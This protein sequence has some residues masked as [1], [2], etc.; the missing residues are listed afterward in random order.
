MGHSRAQV[1][2]RSDPTGMA[3]TKLTL[4]SVSGAC[5]TSVAAISEPH[6]VSS[7]IYFGGFVIVFENFKGPASLHSPSSEVGE[8]AQTKG[9]RPKQEG[10]KDLE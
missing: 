8:T 5:S 2:S 3:Y 9:S 7:T 10:C 6:S 4:A 1:R